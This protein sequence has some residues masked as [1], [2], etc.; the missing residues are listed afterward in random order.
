MRLEKTTEQPKVLRKM[1]ARFAILSL[2][3]AGAIYGYVEYRKIGK[4]LDFPLKN[5]T[6]GMVAAVRFLDEGS[7]V[8]VLDKNGKMIESPG[9]QAGKNDKDPSWR[10]DGHRL[11]FLSDRDENAVNVFRWNF[12]ANKIMRRTLNSRTKGM[13][14]WLP[15]GAPGANESALITSGPFILEMN[16]TEGTTRQVLPPVQKERSGVEGEGAGD[17]FAAMYQSLGQSFKSARWTPDKK[18]VIAVLRGE[19]GEVLIAQNIETGGLPTPIV[20][21][22]RVDFDMH[23]TTGRVFFATLN[24]RLTN[25]EEAPESMRLPDGRIKLPFKHAIGWFDPG[26][27]GEGANGV[28]VASSKDDQTFSNPS[29]SPD[30]ATLLI[31]DGIVDDGSN[32][33]SRGIVLLP[34]DPS[35][36]ANATLLHKGEVFEPAWLPNSDG[37]VFVQRDES[38]QRA[39][40]KIGRDGTGLTNLTKGKGDFASPK[41][42]PQ[43]GR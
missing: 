37:V 34:A 26:K 42:S 41:P 18:F 36:G 4:D 11:F 13:P 6:A 20:A 30:G 39:I 10:P 14:R 9:Y 2:V 35:G 38:R 29:L 25:P 31:L 22:E 28:I 32:F 7:Q 15:A 17:Q 43:A 16:P 8:V 40:F 3:I 21:G 1:I 5:D 33:I 19:M 12:G 27:E 24:Y 23:P